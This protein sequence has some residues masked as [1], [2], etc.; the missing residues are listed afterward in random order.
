[1]RPNT[2]VVIPGLSASIN[3]NSLAIP[4]DF[5]MAV[6]AIA[7]ITGTSSGTLNVQASNDIAP[8]VDEDGLP[9]PENWVNIGTTGTVAIDGADG[10]LI[11]KLDLCY[12]WIRVQFLA[13]N[14]EAGSI[15]VM[16]HTYGP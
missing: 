2:V 9:T 12:K 5:V 3:Q 14:N 7:V 6:S 13:D 10:Y 15:E 4:V 1:M 11:P 16:I 8:A